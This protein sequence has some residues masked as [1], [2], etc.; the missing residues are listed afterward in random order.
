MKNK[1][2]T[3]TK[4]HTSFIHR[5]F[6][7]LPRPNQSENCVFVLI[8]TGFSMGGSSVCTCSACA[9][10]HCLCPG[11]KTKIQER[12]TV[13]TIKRP[14]HPPLLPSLTMAPIDRVMPMPKF[15][16]LSMAV[17]VACVEAFPPPAAAP[18]RTESR[19][20]NVAAV[21]AE[22]EE[23]PPPD[24]VDDDV[25]G[26]GSPPPYILCTRGNRLSSIMGEGISIFGAFLTPKPLE[27]SQEGSIA[28]I[29]ITTAAL[30]LNRRPLLMLRHSAP[31]TNS[32]MAMSIVR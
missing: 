26:A 15:G 3:P 27:D 25:V 1:K 19:L 32:L 28:R 13:I 23:A 12:R 10:M 11:P 9:G 20:W 4:A 31:Q 29:A 7:S 14:H 5:A 2:K 21:A 16:E 24:D 18:A 8:Q 22:E 6:I 30:I 17:G